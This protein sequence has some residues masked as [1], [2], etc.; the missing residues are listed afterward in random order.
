MFTVL[1]LPS[2][3]TASAAE[4]FQLSLLRDLRTPFRTSYTSTA[5]LPSDATTLLIPESKKQSLLLL[6][7]LSTLT[8][9]YPIHSLNDLMT[10]ILERLYTLC[11]YLYNRAD[12]RG[13]VVWDLVGRNREQ[14]IDIRCHLA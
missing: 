2:Q 1:T 10:E 14:N 7:L 9:R 12:L 13:R 8:I 4:S 11:V 3:T 6:T 5:H